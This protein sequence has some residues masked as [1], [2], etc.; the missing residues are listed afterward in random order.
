[1]G[2]KLKQMTRRLSIPAL[3][4]CREWNRISCAV[5]RSGQIECEANRMALSAFGLIKSRLNQ[6]EPLSPEK[7][8]SIP[9]TNPL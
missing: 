8:T 2:T 6:T 1:M 4:L 9:K 7:R 5:W 3:N